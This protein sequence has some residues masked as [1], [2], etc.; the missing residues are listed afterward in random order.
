LYLKDFDSK[1][2]ID[3]QNGEFLRLEEAHSGNHAINDLLLHSVVPSTVSHRDTKNILLSVSDL[4][5]NEVDSVQSDAKEIVK[6]MSGISEDRAGIELLHL[7]IQ[8]LLGRDTAAAKIFQA[9]TNED[10]AEVP[11]VAYRTKVLIFVILVTSNVF[12]VYFSIL[13]GHLKGVDWQKLYVSSCLIQAAID[14]VFNQTIECLYI[15][16]LV[17]RMVPWQE[18]K[19]IRDVLD[20]C[21]ENLCTGSTSSEW[22]RDHKILDAPKYLFV[23]TN[24]ALAYPMLMESMMVSS[25]HTHL[26]GEFENKWKTELQYVQKSINAA[27]SGSQPSHRFSN[28]VMGLKTFL[29]SISMMSAIAGLQFMAKVPL[30]MQKLI[31]RFFE[32]LMVGSMVFTWLYIRGNTIAVIVVVISSLVV[33]IAIIR[34]YRLADRNEQQILDNIVKDG[35][36]DI[37]ASLQSKENQTIDKVQSDNHSASTI[38]DINTSKYDSVQ[39]SGDKA[40][41]STEQVNSNSDSSSM[42]SFASSF[43]SQNV[44]T[45]SDDESLF[46]FS[47]LSSIDE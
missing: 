24:V 21:I 34:R 30:S 33:L 4:L 17:P 41:I 9:K 28:V 31:V 3:S 42:L 18:L 10:Y 32:P 35:K 40:S 15:H 23:S 14:I 6:H 5:K 39:L 25:Y 13:R 7:F 1:W 22:H 44:S 8:D 12:F 38:S 20:G 11:F 36:D 46:S 43:V 16:Y 29:N 26:P 47:T 37:F 45:S 19:K 27:A 2:G